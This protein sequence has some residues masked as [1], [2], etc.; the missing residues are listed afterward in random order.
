ML[1][2]Y[3]LEISNLKNAQVRLEKAICCLRIELEVHIWVTLKTEN[4]DLWREFELQLK[5]TH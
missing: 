3:A 5:I 2:H 4:L 1:D